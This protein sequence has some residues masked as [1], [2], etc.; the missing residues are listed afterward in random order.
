MDIA[1]AVAYLR[2][3]FARPIVFRNIKPLSILFHEQYVTILFD[4]SLSK[5]NPEGET[6]V[7]DSVMGEFGL[8]ALEYLTTGHCNEKSDVYSFRALLL[9]LF[10]GQRITYLSRLK[11]SDKHPLWEC[12]DKYFEQSSVN[13]IEDPVI[14]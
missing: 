4:F 11:T 7:K 2:V 10:T 9:V 13:K 1:N 12:V 5:S 14:V 8:V 3:G 6:H